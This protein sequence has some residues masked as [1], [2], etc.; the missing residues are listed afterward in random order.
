ME[1]D[2]TYINRLKE[3][4]E[5][6]NKLITE[7]E[8]LISIQAKRIISLNDEL[9]KMQNELQWYKS[10]EY[11][12]DKVTPEVIIFASPTQIL[13]FPQSTVFD[14]IKIVEWGDLS[15]EE[16]LKVLY[17]LLEYGVNEF[18]DYSI[19]RLVDERIFKLDQENFNKLLFFI[20]EYLKKQVF[21]RNYSILAINAFLIKI[22]TL[23]WHELLRPFLI[24]NFKLI[25]GIISGFEVEKY[26]IKFVIKLLKF[27]FLVSD[28]DYGQIILE[29]FLMHVDLDNINISRN[30]FLEL[31]FISFYYEKD[32]EII[33]SSNKI[34]S[35]LNVK[36]AEI[37]VYNTFY[38]SLKNHNDID[39]GI[40]NIKRLE[41]EC[42]LSGFDLSKKTIKKFL[43]LLDE[44]KSARLIKEK[45]EA[46]KQAEIERKQQILNQ[47][48]VLKITLVE[49][50]VD[51]CPKDKFKIENKKCQLAIYNKKHTGDP[52]RYIENISGLYCDKCQSF[53]VD[54]SMLKLI[55]DKV[56]LKKLKIE[57]MAESINQ[58]SMMS[59]GKSTQSGINIFESEKKIEYKKI[60]EINDNSN[61]IS[62][63]IEKETI[64][65][66]VT[67]A[68]ESSRF[69]II[70]EDKIKDCKC[71]SHLHNRKVKVPYYNTVL[72]NESYFE[73]EAAICD[74]CNA[75]Y[76]ES[77]IIKSNKSRYKMI[78]PVELL[79]DE[80]SY[81][82]QC[83]VYNKRSINNIGKLA[84]QS[85]LR[86]EGY[87]V[88]GDLSELERQRILRKAI[89]I[90][91]G[92]KIIRFIKWL[93]NNNQ[94][95]LNKEG[96]I[97]NK[98]AI[99]TWKKD[100]NWCID[101]LQNNNMAEI[102]YRVKS[103]NEP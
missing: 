68:R 35:L 74:N 79:Y 21:S 26:N 10:L 9:E 75:V 90:Y 71:H 88:S 76:I 65:K 22:D 58:L 44:E 62:K 56:R 12:K 24:R 2:E 98:S 6:K 34:K 66:N 38:D 8:R 86:E 63:K 73:A 57:N 78:I 96:G 16:V 11:C 50:L 59:A 15:F 4:I 13:Q 69:I 14:Y 49:N 17:N 53:Y 29:E 46:K 54:K 72:K 99:L 82:N 3:K 92:H 89:L 103:A 70:I 84:E 64:N 37:K 30:E 7:H 51:L 100:L 27:Y 31:L 32:I 52:I 48:R 45:E 101:Y 23:R 80:V 55:T 36:I 67:E 93:I 43:K 60:N 20:E 40:Q 42:I 1:N 94:N 81:V 19:N 47:P 91:G 83:I 77:R 95:K 5:K 87:F 61:Y 18:I 25:K 33:N 97:R 41:K 39:I 28:E 85:F 102:V